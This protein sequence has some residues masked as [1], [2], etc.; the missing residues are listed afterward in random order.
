ME[1]RR[2]SRRPATSNR[3]GGAGP[4]NTSSVGPRGRPR[5]VMRR[6]RH[7]NVRRVVASIVLASLLA[8]GAAAIIDATL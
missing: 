7:L 1:L 6:R 5:L 8:P 4:D 2:R 3:V